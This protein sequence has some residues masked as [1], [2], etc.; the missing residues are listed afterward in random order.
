MRRKEDSEFLINLSLDNNK[1]LKWCSFHLVVI[2][3]LLVC[4]FAKLMSLI[5]RLADPIKKNWSQD[6]GC[7]S[8]SPLFS[9]WSQWVILKQFA[10]LTSTSISWN[11]STCKHPISKI[12]E[13]I[14]KTLSYLVLNS[15]KCMFL[16]KHRE[17]QQIG[18]VVST[19]DPSPW[20]LEASLF[21]IRNSRPARVTLR[22]SISI[23]K[24]VNTHRE[25]LI[26][27]PVPCL[28][29]PVMNYHYYHY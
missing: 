18:M 6:S 9:L 21:Y 7:I 29:V 17:I 15:Y 11:K 10:Y 19:F 2:W 8:K 28:I 16:I 27:S 5:F 24:Q 25:I 23:N 26:Q 20:E 22:D 12:F 14:L 1:M 3:L 4:L 13:C